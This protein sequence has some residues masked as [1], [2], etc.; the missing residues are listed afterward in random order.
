MKGRNKHQWK[1]INI[2]VRIKN[3]EKKKLIFQAKNMKVKRVTC[4]ENHQ[5]P[6]KFLL[7]LCMLLFKSKREKQA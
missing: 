3:W 7:I 5:K 6:N 4:N 1:P 2:M